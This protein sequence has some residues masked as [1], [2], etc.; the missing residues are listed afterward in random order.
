MTWHQEPSGT[1]LW[2]NTNR[3]R[4]TE[5]PMVGKK[6]TF[7]RGEGD[8]GTLHSI[9]P[10]ERG[11][12]NSEQHQD[13]HKLLVQ[14]LFFK[15][16]LPH[17]FGRYGGLFAYISC[18]SLAHQTARLSAF[19]PFLFQTQRHVAYIFMTCLDRQKLMVCGSGN[20]NN[21]IFDI[22]LVTSRFLSPCWHTSIA[23]IDIHVQGLEII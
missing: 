16:W 2:D 14:W 19:P 1:V 17:A 5:A 9:S 7:W 11:K 8:A 23:L 13:F 20:K 15:W 10:F 4:S 6:Q 18:Q 21:F 3:V 12:W 22:K